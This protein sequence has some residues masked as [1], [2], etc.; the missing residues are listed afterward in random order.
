MAYELDELDK[1]ILNLL[2]ENARMKNSEIAQRLGKPTSTI[3]E[4]IK[5]LEKEGIIKGYKAVIDYEKVGYKIVGFILGEPKYTEDLDWVEVGKKLARIP[6]VQEVYFLTGQDDY[7]L[8]L[9]ARDSDDYSRITQEAAKILSKNAR[10]ML[11][12]KVLLE[13]SRIEL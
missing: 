2:Q 12:P 8:K 4:R 13:E 5:K 1:Q 6:G 3:Y 7:L 9:R 11:C 10:G